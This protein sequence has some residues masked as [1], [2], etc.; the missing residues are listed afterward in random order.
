MSVTKGKS[1]IKWTT[2]QTPGLLM[3]KLGLKL[4][5]ELEPKLELEQKM[6][7]D[8]ESAT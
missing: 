6:M 3:L 4:R 7:L 8:L 2:G 1:F 5:L